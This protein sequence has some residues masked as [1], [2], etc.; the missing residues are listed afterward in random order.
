MLETKPM[1]KTLVR[2]TNLDR[3]QLLLVVND[4]WEFT[5]TAVTPPTDA[6]KLAEHKKDEL[7]IL[8]AIRDQTIPHIS[9]KKIAKEMWQALKKLYQSD[10][11]YRKMVL[12][13]KLKNTK[14][15]KI[16]TVATYLTKITQ[17]HDELSV[18]GETVPDHKMVRTALNGVTKPWNVFVEEIVSQENLPKWERMWDDIIREEIRR[19][20]LH[21]T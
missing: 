12:R 10:K 7:L 17:V 20:S 14:M 8:D 11:E 19:G 4:L 3:M 21:E 16:D 9:G 13:D 6:N 5:S 2:A 18:V 15:S 1:W